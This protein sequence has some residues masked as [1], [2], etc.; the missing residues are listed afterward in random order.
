MQYFCCLNINYLIKQF[1]F[2]SFV[3][4]FENSSVFHLLNFKNTFEMEINP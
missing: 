1:A 4:L 3:S 2:P